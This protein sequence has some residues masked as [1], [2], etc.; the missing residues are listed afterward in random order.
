MSSTAAEYLTGLFEMLIASTGSV[1]PGFANAGIHPS[2]RPQVCHH[3]HAILFLL[4]LPGSLLPVR[5]SPPHTV[6]SWG[7]P[8]GQGLRILHSMPE[9]ILLPGPGGRRPQA[10][11][12]AFLLSHRYTEAGTL[13][14]LRTQTL[15][16]SLWPQTCTGLA[17][18][19]L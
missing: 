13:A 5:G 3:L 12:T 16:A 15:R 7:I 9:R 4:C 2:R 1:A 6:P 8:A 19:F 11:P 17:F 14:M 18:V 10:L